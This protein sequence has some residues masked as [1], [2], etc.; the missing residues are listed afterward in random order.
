M[1]RSQYLAEAQVEGLELY[2]VQITDGDAGRAHTV[3]QVILDG[4][5]LME[6]VGDVLLQ[7]RSVEC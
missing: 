3:G 1:Q 2:P 4:G 6:R 5:V 7:L